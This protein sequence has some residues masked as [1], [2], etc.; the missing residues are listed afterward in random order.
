V[1]SRLAAL[2]KGAFATRINQLRGRA[3]LRVVSGA[4]SIVWS[5]SLIVSIAEVNKRR[6]VLASAGDEPVVIVEGLAYPCESI[7]R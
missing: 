6:V 5:C 1:T 2:R 3:T 7:G 4:R